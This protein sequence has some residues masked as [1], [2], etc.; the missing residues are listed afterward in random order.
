MQFVRRLL[1]SLVVLLL[2]FAAGEVVVRLFVTPTRWAQPELRTP[3]GTRLGS[4]YEIAGRV[5]ADLGT[6]THP[7]TQMKPHLEV[8]G[9]YDHPE[10]PYFDADGC[11]TYRCNAFGFRDDEFELAKA[12][13]ELR[14]LAIGDSFTFGVGV[15]GEAAWPQVLERRLAE[16]RA[17]PVQVINAGF[18]G[19]HEPSQ[20]AEW[21]ASD[22]LLF[23]PDAVVLGF[24]LNDCSPLVPMVAR[25]APPRPRTPS[26][27]WDL[28]VDRLDPPGKNDGPLDF[29]KILT[30]DTASWDATRRGLEQMRDLCTSAGVRFVV[31]VFPMLSELGPKSPYRSLHLAVKQACDD[32]GVESLDLSSVV[33]PKDDDRALWAHPTDQHPNE[34]VQRLFAD[35]ILDYLHAHPDGVPGGPSFAPQK[36]VTRWV[37]PDAQRDAAQADRTSAEPIAPGIAPSAGSPGGAATI[38]PTGPA[39]DA[40]PGPTGPRAPRVVEPTDPGAPDGPWRYVGSVP[41]SLRASD[42][43]R[44]GPIHPDLASALAAARDGDTI[45]IG[46]FGAAGNVTI[47]KRVRVLGIGDVT[48]P[49][50]DGAWTITADDVL[51]DRLRFSGRG[52][53]RLLVKH[54][55]RVQ[56]TRC[57]FLDVGSAIEIEASG[58]CRVEDVLV[59]GSATALRLHGGGHHVVLH[60]IFDAGAWHAIEIDGSDDNEFAE[61]HVRQPG[62]AGL[63]VH[64]GSERNLI[65]HNTFEGGNVALALQSGDNLVEGNTVLGANHGILVGRTP[66]GRDPIKVESSW[67]DDPRGGSDV[68]PGGNR[69]VGNTV[70][71]CQSE[72]ILLKGARDTVVRDNVLTG[73]GRHALVL[74]SGCDGVEVSSNRAGT[75]GPEPVV[76]L[77]ARRCHVD[78]NDFGGPVVVIGGEDDEVDGPSLTRAPGERRAGAVPPTIDGRLLL[79]GDLHLHST[80]SDGASRPEE[81]LAYARDVLGLDFL[82]LSDHAEALVQHPERWD[83]TNT[84]CDEY[85]VPGSFVTLPGYETTYASFW[86]GHYN[87]YFP[88]GRGTLHA[89]PHDVQ[90]WIP[91]LDVVTPFRLLDAL[92]ADG[93]DFITV[94]HHFQKTPDYW[95]DSPDD[96][97]HMPLAEYTGVHGACF[98][99]RDLDADRGNRIDEARP[100][101]ST[102]E[103]GLRSGRVL[104]VA[105]GSDSH[106]SFPG[107]NGLLAVQADALTRD[108]LVAAIR[109]RRTYAT[110]G[111]SIVLDVD[112]DGSPMGSVLDP[113]APPRV[114]ASV[115]GTAPLRTLR[116]LLSGDEIAHGALDGVHGTLDVTL[117]TMPA[118]GA[119][120]QVEAL[121]SDGQAAVATPVWIRPGPPRLADAQ[122][123]LDK[124]RM[125]MLVLAAELRGWPYLPQPALGGRGPALCKGDEQAWALVLEQWPR[126]LATAEAVNTRGAELGMTDGTQMAALIARWGRLWELP[127]AAPLRPQVSPLLDIAATRTIMGL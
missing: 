106:F 45:V 84:L 9:C 120:L 23:A 39:S 99:Q 25:M 12:P 16:E 33:E 24:C 97:F 87:T 121:Q 71:D 100:W 56:I 89:A 3:D 65:R 116:L 40:L 119:W 30:K 54:A 55:Q 63:V 69:L 109:A 115:T 123:L 62:W 66:L 17:D 72:G 105:G 31:A 85:A 50:V 125:T 108:A 59:T 82:G 6:R 80:L 2:S 78:G 124:E 58:D 68:R 34:W 36:T 14:V 18:A 94:R 102:M 51:V 44:P 42:T 32:L 83:L 10:L 13:G 35:G 64:S 81:N 112:V 5:E 75:C 1:L 38:A 29:G 111:A 48:R 122:T 95:S 127:R 49:V 43:Y 7:G 90:R 118:D 46:P 37:D 91:N 96:P 15:R 67:L 20:Y 117:E 77:D 114:R 107:D 104:G 21:L 19:G 4:L 101:T 126:W 103:G 26:R 98:G 86:Q 47:D 60:S 11:V 113:S 53:P 93:V 52:D 110:T 88:R 57:R 73:A 70:R 8:L 28:I 92:V 41:T 27:L 74:M 61:N 76:L 22:G 79:F